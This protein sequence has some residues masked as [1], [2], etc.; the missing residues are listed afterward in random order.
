M[1]LLLVLLGSLW[2]SLVVK[3]FLVSTVVEKRRCQFCIMPFLS[4]PLKW[5]RVLLRMESFLGV[6]ICLCRTCNQTPGSKGKCVHRL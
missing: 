3:S 2:D 5:D 4:S 6:E 1:Y